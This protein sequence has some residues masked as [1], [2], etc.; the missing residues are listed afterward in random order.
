MEYPNC[1][2]VA[3]EEYKHIIEFLY[4]L[5]CENYRITTIRKSESSD[6][7]HYDEVHPLRKPLHEYL[8][9]NDVELE[10]ERRAILD[11]HRALQS[12]EPGDI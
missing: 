3:T 1:D 9:I 8:E 11:K 12:E 4:W 2:K 7:V 10:K 6:S 5:E